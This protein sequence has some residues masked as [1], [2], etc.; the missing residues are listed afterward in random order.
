MPTTS[1]AKTSGAITILI[2]RRN[3]VVTTV[4][5]CTQSVVSATVACST[6]PQPSPSTSPTRIHAVSEWPDEF[7]EASCMRAMSVKR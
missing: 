6:A 7:P 1:V 3:T 5:P 2:S 4:K